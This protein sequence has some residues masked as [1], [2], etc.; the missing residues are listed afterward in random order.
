VNVQG[1][2]IFLFAADLRSSPPTCYDSGI[3]EGAGESSPFDGRAFLV[4]GARPEFFT[5]LLFPSDPAADC[6]AVFTFP[7]LLPIRALE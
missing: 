2:R 5:R 7:I 4:G 3:Q 1:R 6:L